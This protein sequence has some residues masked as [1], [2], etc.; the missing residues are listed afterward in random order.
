MPS[1]NYAQ[2][3][4][5]KPST[6]PQIDTHIASRNPSII[7]SLGR[8]NV[9]GASQANGARKLPA[10]L[11]LKTRAESRAC[12][13]AAGRSHQRGASV[14][15]NVSALAG[16]VGSNEVQEEDPE[17]TRQAEK[18]LRAR[19]D[20][21]LQTLWLMSSATFRRWGKQ[22]E[23][24][25]AIQEAEALNPDN[26]EVWVQVRL[27]SKVSPGLSLTFRISSG[28]LRSRAATSPERSTASGKRSSTRTTTFQRSCTSPGSSSKKV[29]S[30]LPK[31][32]STSRPRPTAGT[33]PKLGFCSA[34]SSKR[35]DASNGPGSVCSTPSSSRR[36]SRS[37][38]SVCRFPESSEQRLSIGRGLVRT[39]KARQVWKKTVP[40]G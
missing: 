8:R 1:K 21:L 33:C 26:A 25:G 2:P 5:I 28:S 10:P 29:R 16:G 39:P 35:R 17:Q 20:A 13:V 27:T 38:R 12:F 36:P 3:A 31:G 24:K 32:C 7:K 30:S 40:T 11:T 9:S 19:S 14:S 6:G 34:R 15:S 18:A 23:C 37:D 22:Q 4:P